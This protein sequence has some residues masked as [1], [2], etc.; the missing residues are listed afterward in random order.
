MRWG[1]RLRN[2]MFRDFPPLLDGSLNQKSCSLNETSVNDKFYLS[3]K[4]KFEKKVQHML[5]HG[6]GKNERTHFDREHNEL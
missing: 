3:L 5:R 4:E 2:N 6:S 1:G